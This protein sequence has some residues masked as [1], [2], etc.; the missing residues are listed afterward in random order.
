VAP[1]PVC[2][3]NAPGTFRERVF[4]IVARSLIFFNV[5]QII[6]ETI[7]GQRNHFIY[8]NQLLV[9]I[10]IFDT[11]LSIFRSAKKLMLFI[12]IGYTACAWCF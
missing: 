2:M 3:Q 4:S 6:S 9:N 11:D 1:V 8:N 12:Y 10:P 7:E 5:F